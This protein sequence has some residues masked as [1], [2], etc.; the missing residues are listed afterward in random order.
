MYILQEQ[1]LECV[2]TII[3]EN[4]VLVITKIHKL[5]LALQQKDMFNISTIVHKYN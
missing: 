5:L 2:C 1:L 3:I 4:C